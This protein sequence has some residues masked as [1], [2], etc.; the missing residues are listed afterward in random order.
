MGTK[1]AIFVCGQI[2]FW[3]TSLAGDISKTLGAFSMLLD[4]LAYGACDS[5]FSRL[6][7]FTDATRPVAPDQKIRLTQR[8]DSLGH[9]DISSPTPPRGVLLR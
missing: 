3:H 7:E 5:S 1:L 9:I 4:H 6:T 2:C 8:N